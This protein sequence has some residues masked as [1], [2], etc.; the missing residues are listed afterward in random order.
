M[1]NTHQFVEK[2]HEKQKKDEQNKKRQGK[3]NPSEQ[4]PNKQH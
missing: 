1:E 3:G 2:L 4:L